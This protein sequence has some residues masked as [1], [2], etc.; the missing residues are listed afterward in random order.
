[1]HLLM[2]HAEARRILAFAGAGQAQEMAEY[3]AGMIAQL[4]AGGADCAVLPAVT[5]HYCIREL[6]RISPLPLIDLL[7]VV[8]RATAGKQV[9]LFGS[10]Y[11]I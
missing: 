3:L 7:E 8:R 11:S 1:M 5:P 9:A 6:L 2:V 4:Q 10:R